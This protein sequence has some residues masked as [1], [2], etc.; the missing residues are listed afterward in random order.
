M[1]KRHTHAVRV[2]DDDRLDGMQTMLNWLAERPTLPLPVH[3][4]WAMPSKGPRYGEDGE[5]FHVFVNSPAELDVLAGL[6]DEIE[7]V[8]GEHHAYPTGMRR[9]FGSVAYEVLVDPELDRSASRS[10]A[11][12]LGSPTGSLRLERIAGLRE[13]VNWLAER[14]ALRFPWHGADVYGEHDLLFREWAADSAELDRLAGSFD[15]L[16]KLAGLPRYVRPV[17]RDFA[18]RI[19][20]EV[21]LDT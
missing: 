1:A 9:R 20:Y 11:H 3:G 8:T 4:A 17:R 2:G 13:M 19:G 6:F 21:R 14:P 7:P 16:D 18:G 10:W 15:R 5:A 12:C